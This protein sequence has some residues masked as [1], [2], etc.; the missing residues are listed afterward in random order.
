[1]L[2]WRAARPFRGPLA[3]PQREHYAA[4]K[5]LEDRL[6]ELSYWKVQAVG[7]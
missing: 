2:S 7:R 1:L 4:T 5:K 6:S 3:A